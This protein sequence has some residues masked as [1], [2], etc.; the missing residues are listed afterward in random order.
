MA[1]LSPSDRLLTYQR[2][3]SDLCARREPLAALLKPEL[4]AAVNAIDDWV[5]ANAASFNA[6]IPQPARAQ[7]TNTQKADLLVYVVRRR[8]EVA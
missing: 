8:F 5:D 3:I 7:L 6:A 2:Y 4:R 1:I